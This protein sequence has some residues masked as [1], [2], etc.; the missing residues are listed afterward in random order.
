MSRPL[1]IICLFLYFCSSLNAAEPSAT[2]PEELKQSVIRQF[3]DRKA[4]QWGENVPGVRNRLDTTEKVIALTLDACGS[5][6]GKGV[7]FMEYDY[8][9]HGKAPN[10]EQ[11]ETA[12]KSLGVKKQVDQPE[13]NKS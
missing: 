13:D 2:K 11:A 3:A 6:K 10:A 1:L 5:A 7:D 4:T 12:L 8:S 9:W